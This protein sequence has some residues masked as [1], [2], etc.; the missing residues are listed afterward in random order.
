MKQLIKFVEELLADIK[1]GF[2]A[3]I[4]ARKRRRIDA[5]LQEAQDKALGALVV[6][7]YNKDM[8][9]IEEYL[10]PEFN[11]IIGIEDAPDEIQPRR[12]KARRQKRS[13]RPRVQRNRSTHQQLDAL[14]QG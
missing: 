11:Q 9:E 8:A 10:V 5:A 4:G 14:F 1:E 2:R 7:Q 12:A 6:H 13:P 3:F